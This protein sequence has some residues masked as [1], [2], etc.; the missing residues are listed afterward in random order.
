MPAERGHDAQNQDVHFRLVRRV[1]GQHC[2]HAGAGGRPGAQA[3]GI[4]LGRSGQ[5]EGAARHARQAAAARSRPA[6]DRSGLAVPRAVADGRLRPVHQGHP[7]RRHHHRRRAHLG[8][9]VRDRVQRRHH[10]GRHLLPDDRQEARARPG[11]RP[12]EP[13]AVRLPGRQRRRQ[14]AA[15]HRGVSRPRALRPHLL[16]PGDAVLARHSADRLRDGLVHRRR[17]LRAGHVGRI[18]HRAPAGHHLPRRPAAGEGRHRRDGERGGTG[19]RRGAH[20]PVGRGRSLRAERRARAGDRAQH[21]R[22]P[23]HG[24]EGRHRAARA[25][26][27]RST[28]RP[29]WTAWCRPP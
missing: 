29:S 6:A 24:E 13:A 22:Q 21:R 15:A 19:R 17:R 20:A 3:P 25:A 14:P 28:I 5:A 12:R 23:Q 16:Q 7:R 9:R 11:G 1:Q 27:A 4:G 8:A 10:Q 18:D 26:A 2:G